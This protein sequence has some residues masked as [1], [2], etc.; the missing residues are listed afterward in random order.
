MKY[1]LAFS[2]ILILIIS[3]TAVIVPLAVNSL[4]K[5]APPV[6]IGVAFCGNTTADARALIDR[7]KNYTNLFILDPGSAPLSRN[8]T[9]MNEIGDYAVSKGLSVIVNLGTY[10]VSASW[11]WQS[12]NSTYG[13][14]PIKQQWVQRWGS[15]FVGVYYNDEPAG[16]QLDFDWASW[17]A[18]HASFLNQSNHQA[19][20]DLYDI[21][22]K[23]LIANA[24]KETPSNFTEEA[25]FFV[26]DSLQADP[27]M[28]A[29]RAVGIRTFTSDYA[30]YWYDYLGGYDVLFAELGFNNSY[31]QQIDLIRGAAH[32][33]NKDW[34]AII[35]WKYNE[36][37]YLDNYSG[38][39]EQMLTAYQSGAKYITIFDY[40]TLNGSA[41]GVLQDQ[42]F[43]A[44]QQFWT[45]IM[46]LTK[47][48]TFPDL[49]KPQA[50]LVMPKDNG[51]G[52]R[53]P[54]DVNWGFYGPDNQSIPMGTLVYKLI[55]Q[56]GV[57]L[58]I[59]YNDPNFPIVRE[60]YSQ[61]YYFAPNS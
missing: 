49:S 46:T 25:K 53:R 45:D 10:N 52:M 28:V 42:H 38:I 58:D 21:Y 2:L 7:V 57:H 27:G 41:F 40:P 12:A 34:G 13:L 1:A 24:T 19:I 32:L 18:A 23:M 48:R 26:T 17:L 14:L 3:I 54:D 35:T 16:I 22:N 5:A 47:I 6:Y 60:R 55:K 36:T 43:A 37:P 15:K 30:L 20:R 33:Q 31:V 11:F 39:Y 51:W 61:I 44:L 8:V 59:V 29:L 50:V 9:A 4:A 56:Y